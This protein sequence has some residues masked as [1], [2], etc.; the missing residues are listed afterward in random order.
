MADKMDKKIEEEVNPE[1]EVL[2]TS[3]RAKA[4]NEFCG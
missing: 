4:W 3:L 2:L 1:E